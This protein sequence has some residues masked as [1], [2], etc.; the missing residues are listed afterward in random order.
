MNYKAW[1]ADK[2]WMLESGKNILK[3]TPHGNPPI[4]VPDYRKSLS[5]ETLLD[6]C[7]KCKVCFNGH[8]TLWW[9]EYIDRERIE[10]VSWK[11][12]NGDD[13]W[14][15]QYIQPFS[16]SSLK[17]KSPALTKD[18]KEMDENLKKLLDKQD[19]CPNVR[20]PYQYSTH[21]LLF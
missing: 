6:K 1:S 3:A 10:R 16:A 4:S 12:K 17:V 14:S 13:S 7:E 11:R 9:Q 21:F 18:Q 5:V 15:L 2:N 19:Y 8:Q 20:T